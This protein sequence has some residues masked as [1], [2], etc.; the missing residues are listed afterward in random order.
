GI[1]VGRK[2]TVGSIYYC[3]RPFY[4]IDTAYFI[5]KSELKCDIKYLYYLLKTLGL[6]RLNEDSAVPGLNRDTAYSQSFKFPQSIETQRRIA[7]ILSAL[8][9]KIELNR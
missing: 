7:D 5:K 6:E 3:D 8:D 2:G 4:C 9:E 1:I